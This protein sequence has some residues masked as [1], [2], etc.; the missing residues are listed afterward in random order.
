MDTESIHIQLK[1]MDVPGL[2]WVNALGKYW[3]IYYLVYVLCVALFVWQRWADLLHGDNRVHLMT[4][5]F[6][7]SAGVAVN[8][9][10]RGGGRWP[11][12]VANPGSSQKV[13]T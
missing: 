1:A 2:V 3:V 4:A 6:G 12:H 8:I 5:G 13:D 11:Y 10:H 9:R 7:V